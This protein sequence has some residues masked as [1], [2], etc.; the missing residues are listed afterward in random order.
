ML[1]EQIFRARTG[2][3]LYIC[4]R[5]FAK[6]ALQFRIGFFLFFHKNELNFTEIFGLLSFLFD[7]IIF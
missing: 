3:Y 4:I 1:I 6:G 7:F 2:I 5:L